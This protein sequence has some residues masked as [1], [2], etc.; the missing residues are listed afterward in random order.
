MAPPNS[1]RVYT[2][3][4]SGTDFRITYT[5]NQFGVVEY[6]DIRVVDGDYRACGPNLVDFLM[7][8]FSQIEAVEFS[9][10]PTLALMAEDL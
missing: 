4:T 2:D 5:K 6:E 3:P 1:E 9:V 10:T 7:N 8:K